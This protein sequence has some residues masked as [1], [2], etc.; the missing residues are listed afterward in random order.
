MSIF[1]RLSDVVRRFY[2]RVFKRQEDSHLHAIVETLLDVPI[3]QY[4]SH[5]MLLDLA[6]V[7]HR[8][9]YKR[10]AY[11][12][13]ENDPGLGLYIVQRGRVRLL[14]EDE[15]GN[16]QELRQVGEHELLS[17]ISI[18]GEFRRMETVQAVTDTQVLGFFS[19]DM[20]VM[21]KRNPKVYAAVM[22]ALARYLAGRQASIIQQLTETEGK[23]DALR[24][25]EG[26]PP[27]SIGAPAESDQLPPPTPGVH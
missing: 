15:N 27:T 8:R 23:V 10:D 14:T 2:R 16:M 20:N 9:S 24:L 1:S 5:N 25:R 11:I 7:M 12:Y 4:C 18:L 21:A 22:A 19:P 6:Q 13:H 26:M 3:F 17:E